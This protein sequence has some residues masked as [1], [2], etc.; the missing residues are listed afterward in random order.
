[1]AL[2]PLPRFLFRAPLLP[3]ASVGKPDPRIFRQPLFACALALANPALAA[4][5]RTA[6][7]ERALANY[8]RRAAFRP[9]PHG[10]W[11]GVATGTL[12]ARTRIDSGAP[13]ARLTVS[14]ARLAA[15][16]RALLDDPDWRAR[17]RLRIAPS[18]I[19]DE[20]R[21]SWLA[22][23]A[24]A[25]AEA[26]TAELDPALASVL[27]QAR[28]WRRFGALRAALAEVEEDDPAALDDYLLAL[29]DDGLLV[30]DLEPPLV[31]PAPLDWMRARLGGLV[32]AL[33]DVAARLVAL[34]HALGGSQ[35]N[36]RAHSQV[37]AQPT[38]AAAAKLAPA[39]LAEAQ[40]VLASLPGAAAAPIHA[41][42]VHQPRGEPTLSRAAVER[43]AALGPTLFALQEAL[44]SPAAERALDGG[45]D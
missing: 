32:P 24:E 25:E 29:V 11:A 9:T 18:L 16:G 2:V 4:G 35:A 36:R 27:A 10:L 7:R 42:L 39:T 1:M 23:G 45:I 41:V 44:A 26:R 3:V 33:D 17:A 13:R 19:A 8:A 6:E 31:G 20:D 34:E 43:A 15:L 22:F 14:W 40:A 21:A 5:R 28:D 38:L 12:G 37:A 30:H